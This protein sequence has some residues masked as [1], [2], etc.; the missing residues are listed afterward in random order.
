[1]WHRSD[2][3]METVA[4]T[5]TRSTQA[6]QAPGSSEGGGSEQAGDGRFELNTSRALSGL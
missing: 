3:T 5:E 2:E 6:T 4:I 1:M